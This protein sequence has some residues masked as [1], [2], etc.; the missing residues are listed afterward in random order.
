MAKKGVVS[1]GFEYKKMLDSMCSAIENR[2]NSLDTDVDFNINKDKINN[3][4]VDIQNYLKTSFNKFETGKVDTSDFDKFKTEINKKIEDITSEINSLKQ[5]LSSLGTD[6]PIIQKFD[7]LNNIVKETKTNISNIGL[8]DNDSIKFLENIKQTLSDLKKENLDFTD[9]FDSKSA[10]ELADELSNLE[11]E[12]NNLVSKQKELSSSMKAIDPNSDEF[13]RKSI[14]YTSVQAD[15]LK[16]KN[17]IISIFGEENF[18]P[19]IN[20]TKFTQ[21]FVDNLVFKQNKDQKSFEKNANKILKYKLPDSDTK[22]VKTENLSIQTK[23]DVKGLK[24]ELSSALEKLQALASKNPV[25]APVK[26]RVDAE[27]ENS[28]KTSEETLTKNQI[29][30]ARKNLQN[31]EDNIYI[32]DIDKVY[33]NSLRAATNQAVDIAKNSIKEISNFFSSNPIYLKFEIPQDEIKKIETSIVNDNGDIKIDMVEQVIELRKQLSELYSDITSMFNSADV[34]KIL[35]PFDVTESISSSIE[36]VKKNSEDEISN[37]DLDN[38]AINETLSKLDK[39]LDVIN[40]IEKVDFNFAGIQDLVTSVSSAI[41][42]FKELKTVIESIQNVEETIARANGI[43][44]ETTINSKWSEISAY[45]DQITRKDG[46]IKKNRTKR[47]NDVASLYSEYLKMGGKNEIEELGKTSSSKEMLRSAYND[48][49]K[50]NA[51]IQKNVVIENSS[52]QLSSINE[53]VESVKLLISTLEQLQNVSFASIN[54]FLGKI[55]NLDNFN[56]IDLSGLEQACTQLEKINGLNNISDA[57]NSIKITQKQAENVSTLGK[58]LLS[59]NEA[60]TKIN[61]SS[62][63]NDFLEQITQLT[64]QADALKDLSSILKSSSSKINALQ[65]AVGIQKNAN[66]QNVNS[67]TKNNSNSTSLKTST[68][69]PSVNSNMSSYYQMPL[70]NVVKIKRTARRNSQNPQSPFVS[71]KFTNKQGS[72]VTTD[73][74]GSILMEHDSIDAAKLIKDRQ[75]LNKRLK[76][77]ENRRVTDRSTDYSK[78]LKDLHDAMDIANSF[79]DIDL[80]IN[81]DVSGLDEAIQKAKQYA[82]ELDVIYKGSTEISREKALSKIATYEDA[83]PKAA[84]LFSSELDVLKKKLKNVGADLDVGDIEAKFLKITN[85]AKQMGIEGQS[86][87]GILKNKIKYGF[88]DGIATFFSVYD[89]YNYAKQISQASI[90]INSA[91]TDLSKVSNIDLGSL[92]A[93]LGDFATTAKNVGATITDTISATADWSRMGY[94]LNDSKELAKVSLIYKNVGD[95]ID[96]DTANQSLISTLKGYNLQADDAL[97]IIDKFNEVSN[98][99]AIDSGGIGEALQ[100]SAASFNA[101]NTDLSK[102]IALI[103]GTNT[104][105]QNPDKVGNMWKTK[106][107]YCLY[108]QKCA[109]RTY[110]IAGNA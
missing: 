15:L 54:D 29:N 98:N 55:K 88:A 80:S 96:I 27:Y 19:N 14:E 43:T 21:D 16:N 63:K 32:K 82:D 60:L 84:K 71:Y 7:E 65:G 3:S 70:K 104:T 101:A 102:S 79:G 59:I 4:I 40:Q 103:T 6:L 57:F 5:V 50:H 99:F 95:G 100:R 91:F 108:V 49:E 92:E 9:L 2:L 41:D 30:E 34:G 81:P 31:S 56:N 109:Y 45:M 64:K 47:I 37:K 105:V 24:K 89:I 51:D 44:S 13:K 94:N 36:E 97:S 11:K 35:K 87:S 46:E 93:Q 67:N 62:G 107:L 22:T 17:K 48:L 20:S 10:K 53:S 76:R 85:A 58:S 1:I 12:Y 68:N 106:I 23:I 90:E 18:D 39:M 42:N 66:N 77:F 75:S 83:N 110:L 26:L 52:K 69:V 38:N 73:S 8:D 28:Q 74:L 86:F 78:K 72:D 25:I 33:G 61:S